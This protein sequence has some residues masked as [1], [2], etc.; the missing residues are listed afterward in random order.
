MS[1]IGDFFRSAFGPPPA[2]RSST[3]LALDDWINYFSFGGLSYPIMPQQS[4][5]NRQAEPGG[6]FRGLI[7]GAYKQNGIVFACMLARQQLFAEAR[8]QFQALQNGRPGELFGTPALDLLDT[9]WPGGTTADL[10][11]RAIQDADLAGNF[12]V[13]R[14]GTPPRLARLRPDWV[15]IVLGSRSE[16]DDPAGALDMEVAGYLYQPGGPESGKR[17]ITLLREEVAHFAPVPDPQA[18]YRGMSWLTPVIR[19]IMSDGAATEH[20]LAFFEN[21]ATP[22]TVVSLD[23]AIDQ[24]AFQKW[25]EAFDSQIAEPYRTLY[26]GGGADVKVVGSDLR[27]VD[28]KAVQGAT[29]TRIAAAAGVPP[30]IVG[31]SEGLQAATYSNYSQARRRFADGTMRPLWRNMAGSLQVVVP[32]PR[33]GARL[34][35][36]DRDVAFLQDDMKDRAEVQSTQAT[37]MKSLVDAGFEP[38]SVVAAIGADDMGKL[39]HSGLTS[40]QLLPPG[41]AESNGNG[42]SP[43]PSAVPS[44]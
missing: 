32:P 40:V 19:E 18:F 3:P 9:P 15:T 16:P 42:S 26:L 28:F 2:V 20:K 22:N 7:E 31:L 35:Y 34:W 29:E 17:P 13:T 25:T 41:V 8:F 4:L 11:T 44:E 10:L 24:E 21:G 1:R 12:Y 30:V 6:D 23:P 38:D 37:A 36:D 27:Q 5:G 14:V 39:V 43:E 33:A